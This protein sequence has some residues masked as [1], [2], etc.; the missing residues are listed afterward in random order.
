LSKAAENTQAV[1]VWLVLWKT[2]RAIGEVARQRISGS[3]L[4]DSDFRVLEALL[5]KGPLPVNTIGSKVELTPGSISVAVDRLENRGLV[6]RKPGSDDRRVHM[7]HL[8]PAGETVIRKAFAQHEAE[9]E[10]LFSNL[11]CQERRTLI[12]LLKKLGKDVEL[13]TGDSSFD[14]KSERIPIRSG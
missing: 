13:R 5:H 3:C 9:M 12:T 10:R 7:V 6:K 1:H 8:T 11:S 14:A 2:F 4:G